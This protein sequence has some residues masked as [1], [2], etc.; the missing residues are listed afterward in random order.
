MSPKIPV[1]VF[2]ASG[3]SGRLV[4]EYLGSREERTVV[5]PDCGCLHLPRNVAFAKLCADGGGSPNWARSD[6]RGHG[7]TREDS[8]PT[9]T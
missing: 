3:F 1:V 7:G 4:A 8:F 6:T 5:L 2:G 9:F